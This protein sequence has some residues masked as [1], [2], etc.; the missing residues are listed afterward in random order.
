MSIPDVEIKSLPLAEIE[1]STQKK[2]ETKQNTKSSDKNHNTIDILN[3]GINDDMD[4]RFKIWNN[5]LPRKWDMR[6]LFGGV[7]LYECQH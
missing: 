2:W 4:A 6:K 3:D 1:K 5:Y 7:C